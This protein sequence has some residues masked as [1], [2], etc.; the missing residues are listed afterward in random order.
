MITKKEGQL[1]E[2]FEEKI[3]KIFFT[4]FDKAQKKAGLIRR[5]L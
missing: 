4:L 1:L 5:L 3:E 2:E